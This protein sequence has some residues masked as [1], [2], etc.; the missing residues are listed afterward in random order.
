MVVK[1]KSVSVKNYSELSEYTANH[2]IQAIKANPN[3]LLCL[4]TGRTPKGVYSLLA[5]KYKKCPNIFDEIRII[6]LDEWG[7][8]PLSSIS[9]C[10]YYLRQNI[11]KPLNIWGGV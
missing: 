10:E 8:I 4:A 2:L 7:G 3:A 1:M 6:K 11:I 5:K 9:S